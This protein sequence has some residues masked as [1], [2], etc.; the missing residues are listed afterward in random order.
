MEEGVNRKEILSEKDVAKFSTISLALETYNDIFSSFDPRPYSER[1]LSSDFLV[2]MK[3]ASRDLPGGGIQ[4]TLLMPSGKRNIAYEAII[5]RRLKEHFKH[6]YD[7]VHTEVSRIKKKGYL[8]VAIGMAMIVA[9]GFLKMME[10]HTF[11]S[12][13]IMFL[14]EPGGWFLGWTGLDH[15][16][17]LVKE[18]EPESSFYDKMMSCDVKFL[19]Y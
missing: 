12:N 7:K 8:L 11:W 1:A 14:V 18:K 17:Y 13:L 5:R 15:F 6:R 4:L 9:G 16:F 3:N 19:S 2:E 10:N